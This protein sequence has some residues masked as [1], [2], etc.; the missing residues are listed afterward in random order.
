MK[1]KNVTCEIE[2]FVETH[3]C[4]LRGILR[5]YYCCTEWRSIWT[6][7][8]ICQQSDARVA[9]RRPQGWHCAHRGGRPFDHGRVQ[10]ANVIVRKYSWFNADISLKVFFLCRECFYGST[11]RL[12]RVKLAVTCHARSVLR[13]WSCSNCE[14]RCECIHCVRKCD[15]RFSTHVHG[16]TAFISPTFQTRRDSR[17]GCFWP[18]REEEDRRASHKRRQTSWKYK[19]H[20]DVHKCLNIHFIYDKTD[21]RVVYRRP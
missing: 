2:D 8:H 12:S 3:L 19:G 21:T 18:T 9:H 16:K 13:R 17:D 10:A 4:E 1:L 14:C 11:H 7:Y 20:L 15:G 6:T 5:S